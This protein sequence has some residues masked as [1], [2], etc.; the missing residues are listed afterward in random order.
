MVYS[1]GAA[2]Y[3]NAKKP[4][5]N[6]KNYYLGPHKSKDIDEMMLKYRIKAYKPKNIS[7]IVATKLAEKKIVARY[8][9]SSEYGPR[10]LGNRSILFHAGDP[11]VNKFLNKKSRTEFMPFAPVTI[12]DDI[13][14]SY[15][16]PKNTDIFESMKYMTITV[17]CTKYMKK[18]CP[19]VV[20][21]D[22]TARPQIISND[23]N[24]AYY[25]VQKL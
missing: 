12:I 13:E 1:L 25:K 18:Y 23:Q 15:V 9:G 20:H 4:K 6:Q 2:L 8:S 22:G 24:S 14:K 11:K 3:V 21:I 5:I 7:Q 16:I 10:A 19:A 17:N